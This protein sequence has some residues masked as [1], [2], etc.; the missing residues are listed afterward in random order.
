[1]SDRHPIISL[2]VYGTLRPGDVLWSF[3]APFV[4]D[5]GV[6]DTVGGRVY[7]TGLGYPAAIF[8]EQGSVVGRTYQLRADRLDE[9]LASLDELEGTYTGLY[10]RVALTTGRGIVAWAYA[11]GTGLELTPIESGDWFVR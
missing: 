8:G 10:S 4:A 1:M 5:D 6:D 11:Y 7:D 9:A 2:F 3:L